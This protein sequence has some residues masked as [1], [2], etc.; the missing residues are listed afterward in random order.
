MLV[1]DR[2][3]R[4]P[5]DEIDITY[6]NEYFNNLAEFFQQST[7][8]DTTSLETMRFREDIIQ[9]NES[10]IA[11]NTIA[12]MNE[13]GPISEKYYDKNKTTA[14]KHASQI[15]G[16]KLVLG[17]G[18]KFTSSH[19]NSVKKLLLYSDTILIPD[20]VLPW[21]EDERREEKFNRVLLLENTFEILKMKAMIDG[22]QNPPP[23][24]VF[25]SWE[26]TLQAQDQATQD[27]ILG[28][29]VSFLSYYTNQQ[30][31]TLDDITAFAKT[32]EREFLRLV[33]KYNLF[34]A[35][36]T[37]SPTNIQEAIS[38]YRE[39]LR[40]WRSPEFAQW[41]DS[42]P[43]GELVVLGISERVQPIYH[44]LENAESLGSQPLFCLDPHWY[45]YQKTA[46][47]LGGKLEL[48]GLL[49]PRTVAVLRSL[50][51]PEFKWLGNISIENL[52]VLRANNENAAFRK[53]LNEFTEHLGEAS[54]EDLDHVAFDVANGINSLLE[55]HEKEIQKIDDTYARKYG[56]D[57]AGT[58][59][60]S[61]A[62]FQPMLAP[63]FGIAGPLY[64]LGK[65]MY[66]MYQEGEARRKASKSLMGVLA[67]VAQTG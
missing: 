30:F 64:Y 62:L 10:A 23:I 67:S 4:N 61:A 5:V 25:P 50:M 33:D 55:E 42:L 34:W 57:L 35:P 21:L 17:G 20:P 31:T 18:S 32:E 2:G 44:A 16:I 26:K 40:I 46:D 13:F 52:V 58:A 60:S 53:R 48:N 37:G 59:I 1:E 8:F 27:G 65:S 24:I 51:N 47:M 56:I 49:S 29:I 14:Y 38:A 66:D 11:K 9:G 7:G 41:T 54:L 22:K 43:D 63:L 19:F 39:Y 28:L 15:P 36:G 3:A 6:Q 12:A 45:Y